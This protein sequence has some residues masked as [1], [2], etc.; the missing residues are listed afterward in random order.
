MT[1]TVSSVGIQHHINCACINHCYLGCTPGN[2][3]Q[4]G[5]AIANSNNTEVSE[6][7][8]EHVVATKITPPGI[9]QAFLALT[10]SLPGLSRGA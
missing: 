8:S 3:A 2:P 6:K 10:F 7:C 5:M 4:A 1:L 9:C